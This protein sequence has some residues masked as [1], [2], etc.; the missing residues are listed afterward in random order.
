MK[1][2]LKYI[3][4]CKYM[5]Y[6]PCFFK[7]PPARVGDQAAQVALH[8]TILSVQPLDTLSMKMTLDLTL[9]LKWRDPRLDMESLN[10][11]ETLNV[12]HDD[13]LIWRP[14]VI[15][16]DWTMTE[17]DTKLHWQTFVAV[18]ESGPLPDDVTRVREGQDHQI[19]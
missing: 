13:E 3:N 7:V 2:I 6:G 17:A 4:K 1:K 9:T 15:F 11:A 12:I 14:E 18:M 19:Y 5:C 8:V 16:E 10:Y